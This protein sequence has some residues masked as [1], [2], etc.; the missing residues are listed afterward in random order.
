MAFPVLAV[1]AAGA[2]V[3][4]AIAE[5]FEHISNKGGGGVYITG[6]DGKP[7]KIDPKTYKG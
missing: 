3:A 1:L 4:G 7:Q 2:A 6:K 5:V